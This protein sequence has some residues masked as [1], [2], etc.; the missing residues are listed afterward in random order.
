VEIAIL[1]DVMR[2]MVEGTKLNHGRW[3]YKVVN[4]VVAISA[5]GGTAGPPINGVASLGQANPKKLLLSFL[6]PSRGTGR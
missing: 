6:D 3:W 4:G 1:R 2:T 5:W